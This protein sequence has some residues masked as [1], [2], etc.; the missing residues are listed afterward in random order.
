MK[1]HA[2]SSAFIES[3]NHALELE[4]GSG[5]PSPGILSKRTGEGFGQRA[6][7]GREAL[8]ISR[9]RNET[10][11]MNRMQV[12]FLRMFTPVIVH[13]KFCTSTALSSAGGLRRAYVPSSCMTRA[14]EL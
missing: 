1:S 3:I 10:I 4:Q 13:K 9:S 5:Y 7:R 2:S 11:G 12:K 8:F 14:R 6:L